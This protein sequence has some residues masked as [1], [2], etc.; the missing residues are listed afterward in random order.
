MK[1]G[2][3]Q[4]VAAISPTG[5]VKIQALMWKDGLEQLGHE[6]ILLVKS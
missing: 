4:P 1:I 2:L 5:G 6:C 3:L